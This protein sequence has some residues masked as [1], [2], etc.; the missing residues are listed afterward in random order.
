[1]VIM[2][3]LCFFI[4]S[5]WE[6]YRNRRKLHHSRRR[7]QLTHLSAYFIHPLFV[8]EKLFQVPL[9]TAPLSAVFKCNIFIIFVSLARHEPVKVQHYFTVSV[10]W[11]V[12]VF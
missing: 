7:E 5:R 8:R 10:H 6:D 11:S 3:Q 4:I 12:L 9:I 2:S 1:M